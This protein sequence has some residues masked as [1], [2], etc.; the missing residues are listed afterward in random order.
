M[1]LGSYGEGCHALLALSL[2]ERSATAPS[3]LEHKLFNRNHL[4]VGSSARGGLEPAFW[5][6]FSAIFHEFRSEI[7]TRVEICGKEGNQNCSFF[8]VKLLT[9]FSCVLTMLPSMRI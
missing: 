3:G 7:S 6:L 5:V 2:L 1:T 8:V 4:K 9:K